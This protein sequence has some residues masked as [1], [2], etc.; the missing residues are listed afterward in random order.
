MNDEVQHPVREDRQRQEEGG[1]TPSQVGTGNQPS[2]SSKDD[3]RP[4]RHRHQAVRVR[5]VIKV[6]G[7]RRGDARYNSIMLDA[8]EN[9]ERPKHIDKLN[10]NKEQPKGKLWFRGFHQ[11]ADAVV[12]REHGCSLS[13]CFFSFKQPT[14]SCTE[15][16]LLLGS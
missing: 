12:P 11:K 6:E 5:H 2:T 9:K 14:S 13:Q 1:S 15:W 10:G 4:S 7:E 8:Q 16:S 3:G